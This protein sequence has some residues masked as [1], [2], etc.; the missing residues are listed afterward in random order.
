LPNLG[1][2]CSARRDFP[3]CRSTRKR[4]GCPGLRCRGLT[5]RTTLARRPGSHM[6]ETVPRRDGRTA[7]AVGEVPEGAFSARP[8]G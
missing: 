8:P 5:T 6:S 4:S 7:E 1:V 3:R 2:D